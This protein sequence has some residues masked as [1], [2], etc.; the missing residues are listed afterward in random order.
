MLL[1][2]YK[3]GD[4][5]LKQKAAPIETID[6]ELADLAAS[7]GETMY[8][9]NGIGLAAPQVGVSRRLVV[10]DV[11]YVGEKQNGKRKESEHPRNLRVFINPEIIWES[12]EDCS[13]DEGCLSIPGIEGEVFRPATVKVKYQDLQ[14]QSHEEEM[15]KLLGRCIQHEIDHLDGILFPDRMSFLRRTRIAGQLNKLKREVRWRK[16]NGFGL[17]AWDFRLWACGFSNNLDSDRSSSR[18]RLL[19]IL[20]KFSSG[21]T[22]VC[23]LY[24]RRLSSCVCTTV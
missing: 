16:V 22:R 14:G 9:A 23:L 10:V 21:Q 8:A 11:D 17:W 19:I 12:A 7:M 3:Y 4:P 18:Y 6:Q 24:L 5:V 15:G 2:I 20:L 1:D 13:M